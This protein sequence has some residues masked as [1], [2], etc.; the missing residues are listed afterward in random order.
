MYATKTRIIYIRVREKDFFVP[1]VVISRAKCHGRILHGESIGFVENIDVRWLNDVL[2]THKLYTNI[3]IYINFDK[4]ECLTHVILENSPKIVIY[5]VIK[6]AYLLDVVEHAKR[7]MSRLV[8][9]I[10]TH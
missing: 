7:H 4:N 6:K 2:Q 10:L 1:N 8:T 3:T 9:T 5:W